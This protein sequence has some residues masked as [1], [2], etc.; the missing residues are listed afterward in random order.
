MSLTP[1]FEIGLWNG[2]ILAAIF[3]TANYLIMFI[4]PRENVKEMMD[5]V[6]QA[7]GKDKQLTYITWIPYLSLMFCSI[8]VP[9]KL[10]TLWFYFG[11]ALFTSGMVALIVAAVQLFFRKP[12]QLMTEG[13][14]RISR[15]PLYV[16]CYVIWAGIGVA[17]ASWLIL[18]F[19]V[20]SMIVQHFL[21]LSE[22]RICMEKYGASYR[23]YMNGV[24]RYVLFF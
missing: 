6:K 24:P 1:A 2:W 10:G 12:G 9:L 16:S 7:Q 15:N 22:E 21:I 23:E 11:L 3:L 5:Q 19:V 20:L 8:F 18:A 17:T 13:F 14:Y 4:S